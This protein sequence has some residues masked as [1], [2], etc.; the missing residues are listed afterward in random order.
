MNNRRK[1]LLG[2][3]S[4]IGLLVHPCSSTAQQRSVPPLVIFLRPASV[5]SQMAKASWKAF[6]TGLSEN[7]LAEDR[8][9]KL[10]VM[11][12]D[13]HYERLPE[14]AREAVRRSPSVIVTS[15]N[16]SVL[17][18]HDATKSIPIVALAMNNPLALGLAASL[19]RPG[20]NVTGLISEP[21]DREA[22][23]IEILYEAL[24]TVK[25]VAVLADPKYPRAS[26]VLAQMQSYAKARGVVLLPVFVSDAAQ[27]EPGLTAAFNQ[28]AHA[29]VALRFNLL[30]FTGVKVVAFANARR[31]PA[32]YGYQELADEGGLIG[33]GTN[34]ANLYRRAAWYV[35]R[36][37][38]GAKPADLP[39]EQP[40]KFELVVNMKTTKTL[41]IKIPDAILVRA[42][43]VIE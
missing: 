33:Y 17:K 35:A 23:L 1:L 34:V 30:S 36:I 14:L 11:Y 3:A 18:L 2:F 10:E 22:K 19:A 7:G 31:V 21:G 41:G 24:P 5:D 20:G 39:I 40:T 38:R 37:L 9:L 26:A 6:R 28:G 8:D 13:G 32:V 42:D 16:E 15:A 43:R 29:L 4:G 12:A 25:M 27:L